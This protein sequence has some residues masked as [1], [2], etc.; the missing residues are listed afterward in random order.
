MIKR[1]QRFPKRLGV[2]MGYLVFR[3]GLRDHRKAAFD[4]P[5]R[6][7]RFSLYKYRVFVLK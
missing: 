7:D 1:F 3:G 4:L 2:G 5:S 6:F